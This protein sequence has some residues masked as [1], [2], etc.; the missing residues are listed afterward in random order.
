[1][2][3]GS[4]RRATE[5]FAAVE[6]AFAAVEPDLALDIEDE[7]A[8]DADHGRRVVLEDHPPPPGLP[9][10][11]AAMSHD[12]PGLVETSTNLA[13]RV[14]G[15]HLHVLTNTRSSVASELDAL[16]TASAPSHT[17]PAGPVELG[18][19]YPG[20]KP[21]LDSPLLAVVAQVYASTWAATRRSRPSTP[22]SRPASSVRRSPA[23]TWS[24]SAPDRVPHSPTSA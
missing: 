3:T 24:P 11:V 22:A 23:W 9:H 20:W 12:I 19:A 7:D 15:D 21:D 17:W 4:A 14:E 2:R 10:G 8:P 16:R 13:V 1:M 6:D 5:E 18:D